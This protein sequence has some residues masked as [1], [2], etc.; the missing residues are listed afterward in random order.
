MKKSLWAGKFW[1]RPK[2]LYE[3]GVEYVPTYIPTYLPPGNWFRYIN[4][5]SLGRGLEPI[6]PLLLMGQYLEISHLILFI[7]MVLDKLQDKILIIRVYFKKKQ[8]L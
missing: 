7:L 3:S 4:F 5:E 1:H 8:M 6:A 2:K